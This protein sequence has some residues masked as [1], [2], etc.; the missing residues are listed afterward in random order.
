V[1]ILETLIIPKAQEGSIRRSESPSRDNRASITRAPT[2]RHELAP[3][4]SGTRCN[5]SPSESNA[6]MFVA[7]DAGVEEAND[8]LLGKIEALMMQSAWPGS[9]AFIPQ[10]CLE[11][12]LSDSDRLLGHILT[13]L[14][15]K[16]GV[17]FTELL[18]FVRHKA[19]RIFAALVFDGCRDV[20]VQFF[21]YR[22]D[23]TM[24]PVEHTNGYTKSLVEHCPLS[25]NAVKSI[26]DR[27]HWHR[28]R[29][30]TFCDSSQWQILTP[31]F[32]LGVWDIDFHPKQPMP[33]L[34]SHQSKESHFS[35]ITE[36]EI[37]RDHLRMENVSPYAS[38]V[39]L[40]LLYC[41]VLLSNPPLRFL[42]P[43]CR[44]VTQ[45]PI[46]RKD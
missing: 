17:D 29:L 24:L 2:P 28:P 45:C 27:E 42:G 9:E 41:R 25:E 19:P 14:A 7:G 35:W 16:T 4:S 30:R 39:R 32:T 11:R 46:G 3:G 22:F 13:S 43:R 26:F 5:P 40:S 18:N 15:G 38:V 31:V 20:V 34:V 33:F 1:D 21:K 10:H 8:I 37:H 23:D 44:T 36:Y 12:L 6:D